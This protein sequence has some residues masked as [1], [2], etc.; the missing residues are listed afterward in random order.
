M[1]LLS[2][3]LLGGCDSKEEM[4]ISSLASEIDA[5]RELTSSQK[6]LLDFKFK[7]YEDM[8]IS[9]YRESANS[10]LA[11]DEMKYHEFIEQAVND[12]ELQAMSKIDRD[13]YFITKIF[14]PTTGDKWEKQYFSNFIIKDNTVTEFTI[15]YH[16]LNADDI[17]MGDRN[18]AVKS[19]E[20]SI[21]EILESRTEQQLDDE[22]ATQKILEEKML[23]L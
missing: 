20:G 18:K 15:E 12:S 6:S 2:I 22:T 23:E 8:S 14:I 21:K 16:I 1:C 7:E 3:A 9:E 17:T 10:L 11:T 4:N 19:F 5:S 13:A